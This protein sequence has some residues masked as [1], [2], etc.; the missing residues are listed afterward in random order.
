MSFYFLLL[1]LNFPAECRDGSKESCRT[2]VG[3]ITVV[4]NGLIDNGD[5][6]K[7]IKKAIEAMEPKISKTTGISDLKVYDVE[8]TVIES[9]TAKSV[10]RLSASGNNQAQVST[11]GSVIIALAGMLTLILLI[12]LMARRRARKYSDSDDKEHQEVV[13]NKGAL[14]VKRFISEQQPEVDDLHLVREAS[15]ANTAQGDSSF[16]DSF[17]EG[18]SYQRG[19]Q[20]YRGQNRRGNA[21][22]SYF[23]DCEPRDEGFEIELNS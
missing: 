8:V 15:F 20:D 17:D 13:G 10:S 14:H 18:D 1:L 16:S 2:Y 11:G 22:T 23:D 19:Y 6:K 12:A 3:L 9:T 7:Q 5:L 21:A 4:T